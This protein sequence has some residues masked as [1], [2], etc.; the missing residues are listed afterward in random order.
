MTTNDFAEVFPLLWTKD[1]GA[2]ADWAVDTLGMEESWRA[3]G[4]AGRV[5][6]AELHWRGGKV[7]INIDTGMGMGPSG[8]S[9]R[10]DNR[11]VVH[12]MYA[13]AKAAGA[14]VTQGPEASRVA[15]SFTAE[16]PDGN[17]WWVNAETGFLDELRKQ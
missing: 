1:V 9:L 2:L 6:H 17:H 5:E 13:R 15:Y 7:S 10:V 16:D 3:S 14:K 11:Q 8:M 12:D 4:E